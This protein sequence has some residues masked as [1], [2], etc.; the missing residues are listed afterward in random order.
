[1]DSFTTLNALVSNQ[2]GL[3]HLVSHDQARPTST[4]TSDYT[5]SA[6]STD[7]DDDLLRDFEK[8]GGGT[9]ISFCVIA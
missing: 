8:R 1:M 7:R 2:S 6:S 9:L 5:G 4:T 3:E